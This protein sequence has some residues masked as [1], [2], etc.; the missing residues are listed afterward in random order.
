MIAH[1]CVGLDV[2]LPNAEVLAGH[3]LEVP[4]LVGQEAIEDLAVLHQGLAF[5]RRE[6]RCRMHRRRIAARP[7]AETLG[8]GARIAGALGDAHRCVAKV[9]GFL[10]ASFEI[11]AAVRRRVSG[12][13]AEAV[14]LRDHDLQGAVAKGM[15]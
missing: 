12:G 10:R 9:R 8:N 2:A 1:D 13:S 3:R 5:A 11:D 7:G 15:A 6:G 4:F 14:I